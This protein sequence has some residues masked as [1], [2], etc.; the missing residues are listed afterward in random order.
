MLRELKGS[1]HTPSGIRR[2]KR[3]RTFSTLLLIL[4]IFILILA[5]AGLVYIWWMGNHTEVKVAPVTIVKK[6]TEP[7]KVADNSPVGV[8]ES[9]FTSPVV[10]G[11]NVS[12]TVRTKPKAACSIIVTYNNKER[13]VDS[14]LV[15]KTSDEY[16]V[17]SWSWTVEAS[18]PAGTWPVDITCA[19]DEKS[20]YYQAH[21]VVTK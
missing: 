8:A 2:A 11:H 4:C 9:V 1:T 15:P 18:R 7:P 19:K 12:I 14:G 10:A 16:G 20:G 3:R 21:L 6:A 5:C 13:S 17:V